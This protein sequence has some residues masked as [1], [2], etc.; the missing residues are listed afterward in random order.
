MFFTFI[1]PMLKL[2]PEQVLFFTMLQ[3]KWR[4]RVIYIA[5]MI[6]YDKGMAEDVAQV[7]FEGLSKKIDL[8]M[9]F[10]NE[11]ILNSYIY[12]CSKNAALRFNEKTYFHIS[13]DEMDDIFS[14]EECVEDEV[15]SKYDLEMVMKAIRE[16]D[17]KYGD[18]LYLKCCLDLDYEEIADTLGIGIRTA[19][20]RVYLAREIL[21]KARKWGDLDV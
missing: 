10:E 3:K 8:L 7:V 17:S 13:L 21:K 6:L 14:S 18:A 19:R 9:N 1:M 11:K 12:I 16:M 5:V 20:K 15:L 4:K 2:T